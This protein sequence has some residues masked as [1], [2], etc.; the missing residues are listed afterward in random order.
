MAQLLLPLLPVL[1]LL[2]LLELAPPA[3][4]AHASRSFG[5][6]G[7]RHG[8]DEMRARRAAFAAEVAALG[9]P[10]DARASSGIVLSV[11][12][13]TLLLR[14]VENVTVS[15][16]NFTDANHD[17]DWIGQ[18]CVGYPIDTYL[19]WAKIYECAT[20]ATGACSMSYTVFRARCAYEF[21]LF[22]GKQPIWPTGVVLAVSNSVTWAGDPLAP[23]HVHS[24]FGG[25]DAQRSAYVSCSTNASAAVVVQLGTQSGVYDLPNATEVESTTYGAGDLCNAPANTTAPF[26]YEWPGYFHHALIR[27]L[28]PGTRYFARPVADGV[29]VGAEA[30]FVTGAALGADVPVSF[31]AFGDMS[32]TQW[33]Y[34]DNGLPADG[35]G[36]VGTQRRVRDLMAGGGADAPSFVLHFGDLGYAKGYVGLWD[37]WMSMMTPMGSLGQYM[38]SVGK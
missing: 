36:A 21:R 5:L 17:T 20:W 11:S 12:P 7:A 37:A 16:S 30:T 38:V 31:A 15:W 4:A 33:D 13:S 24:A 27:G 18:V 10:A 23:I 3:A 8:L 1:L 28:Q 29:H 22:R 14:D 9:A 35:F 34:G 25:E 2:L 6:P 19:E 32:A 26:Y